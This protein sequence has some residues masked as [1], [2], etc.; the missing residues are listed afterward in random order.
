MAGIANKLGC[1]ETTERPA[2]DLI[3]D[4][5]HMLTSMPSTG[6][7]HSMRCGSEAMRADHGLVPTLMR[8]CD[9]L[10]SSTR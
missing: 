4:K 1:T 5:L 6:N 9:L 8:S 3:V 10:P 7:P 2:R